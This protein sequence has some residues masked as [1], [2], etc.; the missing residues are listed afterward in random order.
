MG[1]YSVS[2][3]FNYGWKKFQ[4][5][6]GPWILAVIIFAVVLIAIQFLYQILINALVGT[7]TA[8]FDPVT[9]EVKV[10]GG[11]PGGIIISSLVYNVI[12]IVLSW[13]IS[14]QFIRGALETT[15]RGKIE[16][17]VFFRT[18]LLGTVIIA[19]LLA[20]VF[21]LLGILAC[22]VGAI[23]V[24][25]FI[26]FFAYFVLDQEQS[27]WESIKSSFSFVNQHL[28]NIIVLYLAS[29]L[30]IVIGALLCLVGL[31]VAVPVVVIAHAYTY[32]A[33]RGDAIAP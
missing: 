30:A 23:I 14:A 20:A 27:P 21:T 28:A 5:N 24:A 6:I 31:L 7:S 8:T 32:R 16:L 2:D 9:G 29:V 18:H 10:S 33:L 4:E 12:S 26:E 25:F 15:K 19:S 3:A 22:F 17:E 13:I 1:K 11:L